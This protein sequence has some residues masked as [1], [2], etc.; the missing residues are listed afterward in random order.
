MWCGV[1]SCRVVCF[2]VLRV[3][4]KVTGCTRGTRAPAGGIRVPAYLG[5]QPAPLSAA[6]LLGCVDAQVRCVRLSFFGCSPILLLM[7]W[8]IEARLQLDTD[9][10]S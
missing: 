4:R 2:L 7:Y 6:L 3:I 8:Y 9:S 10:Q 1:V 5:I